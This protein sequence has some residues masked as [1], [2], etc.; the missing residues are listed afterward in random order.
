MTR[1]HFANIAQTLGE[2]CRREGLTFDQATY[3]AHGMVPALA[4]ANSGFRADR[5][6]LAVA[7]AYEGR[8]V[9]Y[10]TV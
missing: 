9:P 2:S 4:A 1:K 5:F 10:A 8:R 7:D 6:V 3:I